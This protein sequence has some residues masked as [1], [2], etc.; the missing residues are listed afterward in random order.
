MRAHRHADPHTHT[1]TQ[2]SE[3]LIHVVPLTPTGSLAP[4]L[5]LCTHVLSHAQLHTRSRT[6]L[7]LLH[8]APCRG[9]ELITPSPP[10]PFA[11]CS[12]GT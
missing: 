2:A 7:T 3:T 4:R 12:S 11:Q 10:S 9:L 6:S 8:T 5:V 1:C